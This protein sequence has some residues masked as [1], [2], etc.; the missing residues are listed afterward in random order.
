MVKTTDKSWA[1]T[2]AKVWLR[3]ADVNGKETRTINLDRPL[4]SDDPFEKGDINRFKFTTNKRLGK[5]HPSN[6][7]TCW[8]QNEFVHYRKYNET[9]RG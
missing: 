4:K 1:G 6:H 7:F 8:F 3:V 5:S 2:D 9:Q